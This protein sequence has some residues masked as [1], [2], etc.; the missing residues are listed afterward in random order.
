MEIYS[1]KLIL[2]YIPHGLFQ[3][4]PVSK[5]DLFYERVVLSNSLLLLDKLTTFRKTDLLGKVSLVLVGWLSWLEYRPHMPR[6]QAQPPVR[7]H[8]RDN[9]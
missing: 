4:L 1:R 2:P 3:T 7:A 6:W 9:Q 5:S 8:T